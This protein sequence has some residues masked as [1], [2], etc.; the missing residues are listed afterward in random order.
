MASINRQ[1][2]QNFDQSMAIFSHMHLQHFI[3]LCR[4]ISKDWEVCRRCAFE[5]AFRL[6]DLL[7]LLYKYDQCVLWL[8]AV[9]KDHMLSAC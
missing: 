6:C 8:A 5:N 1:I 7:Q 3:E 9:K 2:I 4:G